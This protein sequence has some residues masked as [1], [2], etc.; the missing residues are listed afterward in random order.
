M[1][2]L[3]VVLLG[4]ACDFASGAS[5]LR[6]ATELQPSE[7]DRE[8]GIGS[9]RLV[10]PE[11]NA[12]ETVPGLSGLVGR[13][14]SRAVAQLMEHRPTDV[15]GGF[16]EHDWEAPCPDG[17]EAIGDACAARGA[18]H[19][20]CGRLQNGLGTSSVKDK[21]DF[22]NVC[23]APWPCAG[24]CRVG[25]DYSVCPT[26]WFDVGGGFCE[27]SHALSTDGRCGSIYNFDELSI[28]VKQSM[29]A[30]CGLAWPCLA[31]CVKDY[32][33]PC[34]DGWVEAALGSNY[35]QA[36]ADYMGDCGYSVNTTEMTAAQK[37]DF[38]IRCEVAFPCSGGSGTVSASGV[39]RPER[40]GAQR[41]GPIVAATE[42]IPSMEAGKDRRSLEKRYGAPDGPLL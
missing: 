17:W 19:G 20:A 3:A 16:C 42:G 37:H 28:S 7:V 9:L 27:R 30:T 29:G 39:D 31:E 32:S 5:S 12:K 8:R 24:G 26:G 25:R 18:Y 34:P 33:A 1:M 13:G 4:C 10:G 36:P 22:A 15:R 14:F 21:L 35:C 6:S 23:R 38:A 41:N 2:R 40:E 11:E